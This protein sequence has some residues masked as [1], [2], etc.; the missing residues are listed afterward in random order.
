MSWIC[1]THGTFTKKNDTKFQIEKSKYVVL[2]AMFTIC[3]ADGLLNKCA[4]PLEWLR[5]A[6]WNLHIFYRFE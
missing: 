2:F 6:S 5:G 3:N 4:L 1:E